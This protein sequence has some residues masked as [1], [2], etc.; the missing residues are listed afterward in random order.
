[1]L[2]LSY[3]KNPLGDVLR[4]ICEGHAEATRS[5]Y[6][7]PLEALSVQGTKR[8]TS[9]N[10]YIRTDHEMERKTWPE[11]NAIDSLPVEALLL[12]TPPAECVHS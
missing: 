2:N 8:R 3:L 7:Q 12:S 9:P 4:N 1:M 6:R 10:L 5:V 11:Q